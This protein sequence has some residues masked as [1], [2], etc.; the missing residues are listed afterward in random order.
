ME[1]VKE[2]LTANGAKSASKYSRSLHFP[3]MSIQIGSQRSELPA[4]GV[5]GM[6]CVTLIALMPAKQLVERPS[7][8]A[9]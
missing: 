8:A 2:V 5:V 9:V 1:Q 3:I 7:N 6:I 4:L